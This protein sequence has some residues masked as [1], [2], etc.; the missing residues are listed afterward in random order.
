MMFPMV[1]EMVATEEAEQSM[2]VR[3][4]GLLPRHGLVETSVDDLRPMRYIGTEVEQ[5]HGAGQSAQEHVRDNVDQLD[6]EHLAKNG[7]P[8]EHFRHL[9]DRHVLEQETKVPGEESDRSAIV[10]IRIF[11]DNARMLVVTPVFLVQ[12]LKVEPGVDGDAQVAD[13]IVQ[14]SVLERDELL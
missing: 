14:P 6:G 2:G 11:V 1:I 10:I 3:G 4:V 8:D 13:G 9:P 5:T 7:H 12:D